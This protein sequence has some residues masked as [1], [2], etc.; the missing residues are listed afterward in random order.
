MNSRQIWSIGNGVDFNSRG[1]RNGQWRTKSIVS[2]FGQVDALELNETRFFYC[3]YQVACV[4][5][6]KDVIGFRIV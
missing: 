1:D 4:V 6:L 5:Y 3:G 2:S